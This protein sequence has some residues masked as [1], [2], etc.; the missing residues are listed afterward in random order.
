MVWNSWA[1]W[2]SHPVYPKHTHMDIHTH[3]TP[4]QIMKLLKMP[5]LT[6]H[7]YD[8]G[9]MFSGTAEG[10]KKGR[11]VLNRRGKVEEKRMNVS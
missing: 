6:W 11:G 8:S 5:D 9:T 1:P 2:A 7:S 4:L 10:E 3:T